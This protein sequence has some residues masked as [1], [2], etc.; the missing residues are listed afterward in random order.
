MKP[1]SEP[2]VTAPAVAVPSYSREAI[3]GEPIEST[4]GVT[5]PVA[6]PLASE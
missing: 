3:D 4:L 1:E 2:T 6:V 5:T